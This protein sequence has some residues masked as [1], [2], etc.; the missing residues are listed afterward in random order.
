VRSVGVVVVP[1]FFDDLRAVERV[2]QVVPRHSSRRRPLKFSTKPFCIG[3]PARCSAIRRDVLLPA[4]WR[5][6]ST[7]PLSLTIMQG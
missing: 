2:E 5:L 3:L 1:P 6:R 7:G 4:R